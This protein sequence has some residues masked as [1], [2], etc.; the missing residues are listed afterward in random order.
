M[1]KYVTMVLGVIVMIAN[2]ASAEYLSD[3]PELISFSQQGWGTLGINAC[4]HASGQTPLPL[5]IKDKHYSKG[6]GHHAPGEILVDLDGLYE[7][8]EAEVG[9]QWQ[10]GNTGSV[11]F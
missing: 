3:A 2:Q 5:Q 11:V 10:Q 1:H 9:V 4:A 7:T 8:F 6:L